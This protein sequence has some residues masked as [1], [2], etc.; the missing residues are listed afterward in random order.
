MLLSRIHLDGN[1]AAIRMAQGSLERFGQALLGFPIDFQ[2][3]HHD[4][5]CMFFGFLQGR[6]CVHLIYLAV[7]TQTRET[8]R[9]QLVEQIQLLTFTFHH[10]GRKNHDLC[11]YG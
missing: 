7:D 5:D 11:V 9:A 3:V 6:Q 2:P 4:L 8:L 10:Q 1:G